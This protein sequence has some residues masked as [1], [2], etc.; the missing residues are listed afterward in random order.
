MGTKMSASWE[1]RPSQGWQFTSYTLSRWECSQG[2]E[3][4]ATMDVRVHSWYLLVTVGIWLNW[5]P[6]I[7]LQFQ[8]WYHGS[9]FLWNTVLDILMHYNSRCFFDCV[10]FLDP[11]LLFPRHLLPLYWSAFCRF[12]GEIILFH[13]KTITSRPCEGYCF[14]S[15]HQSR[16]SPW[17]A[18]SSLANPKCSLWFGYLD[19]RS[20]IQIFLKT[21][22][23]GCLA[24]SA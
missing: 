10:Y 7:A 14:P 3:R 1:Y 2:S 12:Q 23:R 5:S 11:S 13:D 17:D 4:S 8:R 15:I 16:R 9:W 24:Q 21:L 20:Q 6:S 18:R 22:Q 19:K